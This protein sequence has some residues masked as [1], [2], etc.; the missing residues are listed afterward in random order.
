LFSAVWKVRDVVLAFS[1]WRSWNL[2]W[3]GAI[4]L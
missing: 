2:V 3:N 1:F 4:W